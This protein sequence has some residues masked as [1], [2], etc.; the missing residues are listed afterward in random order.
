MSREG[1]ANPDPSA[2]DPFLAG[3]DVE[4]GGITSAEAFRTF[5]EEAP[6][7]LNLDEIQP[8]QMI[9]IKVRRPDDSGF[10][11]LCFMRSSST[12]SGISDW[13]WLSGGPDS[14]HWVPVTLAGAH[15]SDTLYGAPRVIKKDIGFSFYESIIFRESLGNTPGLP[16]TMGPPET[17][18]PDSI[19][20][21]R[22]RG[23]LISDAQGTMYWRLPSEVHETGPVADAYLL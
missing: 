20:A 17:M 4:W 18:H 13:W 15:I 22:E 14:D 11:R 9:A 19:A 2:L 7:L 6:L 12:L 16:G 8:D 3:L 10:T 5:M 1:L 21:C 23:L